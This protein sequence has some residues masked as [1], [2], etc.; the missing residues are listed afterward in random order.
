VLALALALVL[1]AYTGLAYPLVLVG[2]ILGGTGLLVASLKA[3]QRFL[4]HQGRLSEAPRFGFL[5][6]FLVVFST[7]SAIQVIVAQKDYGPRFS[8]DKAPGF[9]VVVLLVHG[10]AVV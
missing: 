5:E 1:A 9:Q 3:G 8:V 7:V 4:F 2:P 10:I 6:L